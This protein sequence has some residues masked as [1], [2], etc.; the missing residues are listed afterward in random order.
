MKN[1]HYRIFIAFVLLLSVFNGAR[2]ATVDTVLT[3]SP[4]MNKSIKAVVIKSDDYS[5]VKALPVVYLLHGAGGNYADWVTKVPMLKA[6]VDQY[7][8]LIVCP[9][10]NPTSWYFDSPVDPKSKYETYISSELVGWIDSHYNTLHDRSKRAIAGLSM[11]GHGAF[12]IAFRHQDVFGAAGSMSGGLDIRGFP[13]R[14]KLKDVLGDY[15]TH[16][17]NWE[18]NTVINMVHLLTPNSLALI[19]DCGT[20]DF[21]YGA[22]LRMH[23]LLLERNIPHVYMSSPGFH[24]W[25]FWAKYVQYELVFFNDYFS[26]NTKGN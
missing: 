9:D 14:W 15:A 17:E 12:Y 13:D 7:Q 4:S 11:G 24:S 8:I 5:R 25:A 19:M 3:E 23:E 26:Q 6:L 2:A 1:F 18:Q 10:G 20:D 22:N 16:P 21:F